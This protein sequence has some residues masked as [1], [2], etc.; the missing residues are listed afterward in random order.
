MIKVLLQSHATIQHFLSL[1]SGGLLSCCIKY[2]IDHV[3]HGRVFSQSTS[4]RTWN[5]VAILQVSLNSPVS[6]LG[7]E[8]IT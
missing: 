5:M 3:H 2:T 1:T 8:N 7:E 4:Q 6:G